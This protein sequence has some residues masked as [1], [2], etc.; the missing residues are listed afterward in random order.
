MMT[1]EKFFGN[2]FDE[3]LL[4]ENKI[5]LLALTEQYA[6]LMP[7]FDEI[8]RAAFIFA[9]H[10]AAPPVASHFLAANAG[11]LFGACL[12]EKEFSGI[13]FC[14]KHRRAVITK[15][16]ILRLLLLQEIME[17]K[18]QVWWQQD[19]QA[20]DYA[21]LMCLDWEV[22]EDGFIEKNQQ[23]AT[24][25]KYAWWVQK[26]PSPYP[27][28]PTWV[29]I[30]LTVYGMF[31]LQMLFSAGLSSLYRKN[32]DYDSLNILV[33]LTLGLYF[34]LRFVPKYYS[35]ERCEN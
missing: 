14:T 28:L 18:G 17:Y 32:L 25:R 29:R 11:T 35:S 27:A 30:L 6:P 26:Q 4:D 3:G 8:N 22:D 33:W 10:E 12:R 19:Q 20:E 23:L 2:S 15:A 34:L 31:W 24:E 1:A 5:F 21:E 7:K 9:D 16:E 13:V